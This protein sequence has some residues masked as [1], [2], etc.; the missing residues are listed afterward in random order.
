MRVVEL[1]LE[2]LWVEVAMNDIAQR[3]DD[4]C[5]E[6]AEEDDEGPLSGAEATAIG[7]V[8]AARRLSVLSL[9]LEWGQSSD[10]RV[11]EDRQ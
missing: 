11:G 2:Q 4:C 1:W 3:G 8:S 6:D 5:S 10:V 7:H 9:L